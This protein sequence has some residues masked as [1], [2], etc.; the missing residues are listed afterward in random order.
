V[1][2]QHKVQTKAVHSLP[3]QQSDNIHV[4]YVVAFSYIQLLLV[5]L[6]LSFAAS[7]AAFIPQEFPVE[8]DWHVEFYVSIIARSQLVRLAFTSFFYL[9]NGILTIL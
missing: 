2:A 6:E 1:L 7:T 5:L 8:P 9:F 3:S 4:P